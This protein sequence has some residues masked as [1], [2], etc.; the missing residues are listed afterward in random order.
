[1]ETTQYPKEKNTTGLLS[2]TKL[3]SENGRF[4]VVGESENIKTIYDEIFPSG[5]GLD[6]K[7]WQSSDIEAKI[8]IFLN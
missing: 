5:G 1:M 4:L 8:P 7:S 3:P 6:N 2:I